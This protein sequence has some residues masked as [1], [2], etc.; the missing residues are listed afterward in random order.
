MI[1]LQHHVIHNS[2]FVSASNGISN[3]ITEFSFL[4]NHNI[5]YGGVLDFENYVI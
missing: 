3:I 2:S 1:S 5:H 4:K